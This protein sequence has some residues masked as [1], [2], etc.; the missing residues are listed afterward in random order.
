[1][2]DKPSLF[3]LEILKASLGY[4]SK[5]KYEELSPEEWSL[6]CKDGKC[7]MELGNYGFRESGNYGIRE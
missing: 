5:G 3:L 6:Q 1:M 7:L 4:E 2:M